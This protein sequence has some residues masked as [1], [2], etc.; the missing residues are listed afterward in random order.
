[1]LSFNNFSG[2]A[3]SVMMLVIISSSLFFLLDKIF[4]IKK[5]KLLKLRLFF[6]MNLLILTVF[7]FKGMKICL[8]TLILIE[9]VMFGMA[10][11]KSLMKKSIIVITALKVLS[12]MA[13][14]FYYYYINTNSSPHLPVLGL[15][16][17][18][19]FIIIKRW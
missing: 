14:F 18:F 13:Y 7:N 2:D 15:W 11:G 17:L 8:A 1:M 6:L 3:L 16:V 12:I 19:N 10:F 5:V 4:K 9:L